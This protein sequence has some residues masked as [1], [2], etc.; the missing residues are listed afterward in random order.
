MIIIYTDGACRGNQSKENIGAYAYT[1]SYKGHTKEYAEARANTTNNIMELTAIYTA[2]KA[3]KRKDIPVTVYSDSAYVVNG[4]NTW[5]YGWEAKR[6]KGVKN[7]QLWKQL[8][9]MID[10]F[11]HIEIKKVTGHAGVEGNEYV[12]KL[13]NEA[14]NKFNS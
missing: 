14:M 12:D 7:S 6:F 3:L 5:R 9:D 13:C 10:T 4:C 2:L 1:L 8:L 11:S